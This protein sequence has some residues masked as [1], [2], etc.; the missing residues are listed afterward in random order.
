V[1]ESWKPVVGYEGIYEVSDM[2]RV[3]RI[4][5]SSYR[6]AYK[7]GR[8]LK[9]SKRE[10]YVRVELSPSKGVRKYHPVH[11]LVA[12]AFIGPCPPGKEVNHI[13]GARDNNCLENLEY[14]TRLENIE[15]SW[16][17]LGREAAHGS[18][19]GMSVITEGQVR[20]MKTRMANGEMPAELSREY[21]L[22][23]VNIARIAKGELWAH[24]VIDPESQS[25]LDE[26]MRLWRYRKHLKQISRG[27]Y[28]KIESLFKQGVS[29]RS[30]AQLT[31][32]PRSTITHVKSGH[33]WIVKEEE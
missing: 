14:L 6:S 16:A 1:T 30:A 2:G 27:D 29:I 32:L 25:K 12:T 7:A 33:F 9:G 3:R 22:N 5:D 4:V 18:Q 15:H 17:V 24:V 8:I 13:D 31:G 21:G 28:R 10:G 19:H 20:E 26:Q 23:R 11:A